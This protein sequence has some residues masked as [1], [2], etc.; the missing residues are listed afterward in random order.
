MWRTALAAL[1]VCT[2][3]PGLARAGGS[4]IGFVSLPARN[5]VAVLSL[6][7]G[8]RLASIA[9]P[10]SPGAIAASLNGRRVLVASAAAGTVTEI[11]GVAQAGGMRYAVART[12]DGF[13]RPVDVAFDFQPPVGVVTPRY[14]FVLD[15]SRGTLTVLDLA[16]GRRVAEVG[17]GRGAARL[18]VKGTTVW[19]SHVRSRTLAR[20][21]I[22]NPRAPRALASLDAGGIVSAVLADPYDQSVF[23]SLRDTPI[24]TRY[25]DVD[26]HAVRVYR[27][28]AGTGSIVGLAVAPPSLLIAADASGRAQILREDTGRSVSRVRVPR[29]VRAIDVYGSY[30][31]ATLPR[32]LAFVAVP[33]ASVRTFVPLGS[34]PGGFSSA[35]T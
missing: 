4:P 15:G 33:D 7:G 31:V 1:A 22:G 14:G 16:R 17:V 24:V 23:V 20:V 13:A 21:D 19:V 6:P 11:D 25:V 5:S 2:L 9:V 35:V 34:V 12:F 27:R 10:R 32:A 8:G 29:G 3:V 18:A 30:L 26:G 28:R